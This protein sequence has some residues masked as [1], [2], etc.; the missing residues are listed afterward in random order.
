M[1]TDGMVGCS[2]IVLLVI[3]YIYFNIGIVN[4]DN[5]DPIQTMTVNDETN[6]KL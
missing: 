4:S 6:S 5:L 3:I 1:N 2:T